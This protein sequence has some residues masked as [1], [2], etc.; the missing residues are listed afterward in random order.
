M[1]FTALTLWQCS[2]GSAPARLPATRTLAS[3]GCG[4]LSQRRLRP[5]IL[6]STAR[7]FCDVVLLVLLVLAGARSRL[8][9]AAISS[10]HCPPSA[11]TCSPAERG[12]VCAEAP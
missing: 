8:H 7:T 3:S 5:P 6:P 4:A 11:S 1:A 10:E 2:A 9:S 12:T